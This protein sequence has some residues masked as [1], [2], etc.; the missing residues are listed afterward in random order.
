VFSH[1]TTFLMLVMSVKRLS[2]LNPLEL[3]QD[4]FSIQ[5]CFSGGINKDPTVWPGGARPPTKFVSKNNM[6]STNSKI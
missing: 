4:Y 5:L 6:I 3:F 1:V 2:L